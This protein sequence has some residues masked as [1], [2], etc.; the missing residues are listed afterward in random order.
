GGAT[1]QQQLTRTW[2]DIFD[3]SFLDASRGWVSG[4]YGLIMVTYDGGGPITGIAPQPHHLP[5]NVVLY[6][7]YPNPFNPTTEIRFALAEGGRV[8]LK[9]YD[10]LG[11]EVKTL[12]GECRDPGRYIVQWDGTNDAGQP[13]ASGVYLYRLKAGDPTAGPGQSYTA[14]RKMLLVR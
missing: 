9:I 6:Q 2:Y 8:E 14:V 10:L 3:C 5:Q 13:V 4:D 11:R 1:W 12:L 7:N